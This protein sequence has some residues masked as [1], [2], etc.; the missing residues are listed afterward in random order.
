M[1]NGNLL[2]VNKI[3]FDSPPLMFHFEKS[4]NKF[5]LFDSK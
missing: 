5:S 1:Q 3:K 2:S 4:C